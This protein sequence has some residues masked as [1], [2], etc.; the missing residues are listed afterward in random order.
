M[1]ALASLR[2]GPTVLSKLRLI[3]LLLMGNMLFVLFTTA[4]C[5]IY[6]SEDRQLLEDNIS[7]WLTEASVDLP[8]VA[9]N[10]EPCAP[11]LLLQN[12]ERVGLNPTHQQYWRGD[13]GQACEFFVNSARPHQRLFGN[14]TYS[15][16]PVS[17][18]SPRSDNRSH[19]RLHPHP[20]NQMMADPDPSPTDLVPLIKSSTQK[21]ISGGVFECRLYQL[22]D[23]NSQRR[24][25]RLNE[26]NHGLVQLIAQSLSED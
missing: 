3:S 9:P 20:E 5:S 14:C 11:M 22:A 18:N 25:V 23:H 10:S 21:N 1:L 6:K 26:M 19:K 12:L 8:L 24:E 16:V 15:Q 17:G 7:Q 4:S 2:P 13:W